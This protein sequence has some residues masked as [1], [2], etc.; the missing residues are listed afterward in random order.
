MVGV[1]MVETPKTKETVKTTKTVLHSIGRILINKIKQGFPNIALT[2][3]W[4]TGNVQPKNFELEEGLLDEVLLLGIPDNLDVDVMALAKVDNVPIRVK[5]KS[6]R[7]QSQ[8]VQKIPNTWQV[9]H[10]K[11]IIR[12]FGIIAKIAGTSQ[13]ENELRGTL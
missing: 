9:V 5:V 6:G 12:F 1:V 8:P 4:K 7:T 11:I 13:K 10:E 3:F 2:I